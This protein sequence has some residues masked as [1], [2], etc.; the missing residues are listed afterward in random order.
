MSLFN[1]IKD[2]VFGTLSI[3]S[4]NLNRNDNLEFNQDGEFFIPLSDISSLG[5]SSRRNVR[6]Y[7]IE[8]FASNVH[9]YTV[10]SHIAEILSNLKRNIKDEKGEPIEDQELLDLLKSPNPDETGS[11]FLEKIALYI[12]ICGECYIKRIYVDMSDLGEGRT[13]RRLRILYL[14]DV[15]INT[16]DGYSDSP[17]SSYSYKGQTFLPSEIIHIKLPN[18]VADTKYGFAPLEAATFIRVASNS[19]HAAEAVL[20]KKMGAVGI[21]TPKSGSAIGA[22]GAKAKK[23][24]ETLNERI[25]GYDKFSDIYISNGSYDY[26][27]IG[28]TPKDLQS[29][30]ADQN[31]LRQICS[32]FSMPSVKFN[33]PKASTY[34]NAETADK[35]QYTDAIIPLADRI[36]KAI[37]FEVIQKDFG[38]QNATISVD[39]SVISALNK[40]DVQKAN[41]NARDVNSYLAIQK[42]VSLGET[43]YSAGVETLMLVYNMSEEDAIKILG[44]EQERTTQE[45]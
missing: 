22:S 20:H 43:Q 32:L 10:T 34:N 14:P 3:K 36:D 27:P 25:R 13:A 39:E 1:Q 6:K 24:Q 7:L 30:E 44:Y 23:D 12:M 18:I 40:P 11:D 26:L 42:Q 5:A 38:Y 37:S 31:K 8:G 45:A 4:S 41:K 35:N 29:I 21:L 15:V 16:V 19:I 17:I 33:D 9:I 28:K 2:F